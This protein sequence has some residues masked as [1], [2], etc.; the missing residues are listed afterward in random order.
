M[1]DNRTLIAKLKDFARPAG[2]AGRMG[3]TAGPAARCCLWSCGTD[4]AF[5]SA[6]SK[7]AMCRRRVRGAE[8]LGQESSLTVTG[9]GAGGTA[10]SADSSWR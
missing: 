3:I 5:A 4:R 6:S 2:N 10:A 8:R 1:S 7:R 9:T